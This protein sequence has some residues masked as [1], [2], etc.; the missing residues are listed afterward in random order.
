VQGSWAALGVNFE[1]NIF[2]GNAMV[3]IYG[4]NNANGGYEY[5]FQV[6]LVA[7]NNNA[8][9]K[10]LKSRIYCKRK[11]RRSCSFTSFTN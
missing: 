2:M 5:I 8:K 11:A 4:R 9:L 1:T 7:H 6:I 3:S 10:S